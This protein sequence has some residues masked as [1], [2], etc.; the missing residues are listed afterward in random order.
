[1]FFQLNELLRWLGLTAFEI[2]TALVC[3]LVFTVLVTLK[4]EDEIYALWRSDF[5]IRGCVNISPVA[6]G[7]DRR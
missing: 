4:V 5:S 3:F 6:K 7:R 1:M 2:F